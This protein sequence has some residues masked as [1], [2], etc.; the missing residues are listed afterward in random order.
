MFVVDVR[1]TDADDEPEL[2]CGLL[3]PDPEFIIG[4]RV[5]VTAGEAVSEPSK[6]ISGR[7]L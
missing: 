7:I 4:I 6:V 3:K 2:D 5:M 1:T